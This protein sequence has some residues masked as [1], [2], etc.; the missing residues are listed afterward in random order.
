MALRSLSGNEPILAG[1]GSTY[2]IPGTFADVELQSTPIESQGFRF[3]DVTVDGVRYRM[4]ETSTL[5][6]L[7]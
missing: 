5:P 3:A 2:F 1:S 7:G 4:I 6:R